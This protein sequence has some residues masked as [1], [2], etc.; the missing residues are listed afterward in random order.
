MKKLITAALLL[1]FGSATAQSTVGNFTLTDV[2]SGQTISLADYAGKPVVIVFTSNECPYD[3]Y[4]ASRLSTL[5]NQYG[6]RV[7]FL[8]INAHLDTQE[9]E[10]AMKKD[11]AT[12]GFKAPYLSDKAQSAM[13]LLGARRSPEAFVLQPANG[14]FTVYY[15]GGIDDNPQEAGAVTA[16]YLR[17]AIE[18]LLSGKA[19]G[20]PM[21]AAG[22]S[23]R[24]K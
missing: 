18:N 14:Q 5:V 24:R 21:R 11:A 15:S 22:C 9:A 2:T 19:A 7:A 1:V 3:N 8:F 23:I 12:W 4:Y 20:P 10:D 16:Q 13:E 6:T 17:D